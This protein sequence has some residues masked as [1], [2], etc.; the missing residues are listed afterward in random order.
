MNGCG[1]WKGEGDTDNRGEEERGV[2][3]M[4]EHSEEASRSEDRSWM[5][6]R[7]FSLQERGPGQGSFSVIGE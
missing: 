1:C 6:A 2:R 4:K 5:Q 3:H 7:S